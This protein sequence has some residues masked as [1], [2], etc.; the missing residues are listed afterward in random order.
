L[1]LPG[2]SGTDPPSDCDRVTAAAQF[3]LEDRYSI[4]RFQSILPDTGA[5]EFLTA[6]KKQ[7]LALQ[8]EDPLISLNQSNAGMARVKFGNGEPVES[9]GSVNVKTPI[10]TITFHVL[11][12]PTLFLMCF[13]NMDRLKVYFN[14]IINKIAFADGRLRASIIR[15]WGHFWFFVSKL[16]S[17]AFFTDEELKRLYRRFGHSATD[18]LCILLKRAGHEDHREAFVVI[19]KF[20]HYCQMKSPKPRCFKFTFRDDCEFNHEIFVNVLYLIFLPVL[21]VVDQATSFQEARFL[22]LM[23]AY[24]TWQTLRELWI[25][26]YQGPPD[27]VTYNTGTNFA[28]QEFRNETRTLAINFKQ[29][30]VEAY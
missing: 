5:F 19:E 23:T 22:P 18:K 24:D 12:A 8:R 3:F 20:C 6:G 26:I 28:F 30:P 10:R 13:R 4:H 21:Q 27:I 14:N 7:F 1:K 15:K 2:A 17:A 11:K 16:E 9:I 25:D 29:I